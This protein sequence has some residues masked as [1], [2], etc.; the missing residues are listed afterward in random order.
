MHVSSTWFLLFRAHHQHPVCVC[1][2]ISACHM[3]HLSHTWYDS[4]TIW[5]GVHTTK[6][7][8]M[9]FSPF[10]YYFFLWSLDIFLSTVFVNTLSLCASCNAIH[11]IAQP[12]KTAGWI[13]VLCVLIFIFLDNKHGDSATHGPD[14]MYRHRV[15]KGIQTGWWQYQTVESCPISDSALGRPLPA[16][17]FCVPLSPAGLLNQPKVFVTSGYPYECV[18]GQNDRQI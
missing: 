10:F 4:V 15:C 6:L 7:L 17:C 12:C 13:L 8:I 18:C 2:I 11:Q 5:W 1:L 9:N 14:D 3:S 16:Y